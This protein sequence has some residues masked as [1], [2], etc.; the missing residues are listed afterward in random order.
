MNLQARRVS[1]PRQ[2]RRRK[3]DQKSWKVKFCILLYLLVT[4]SVFYGALNYSIDLNR[5]ISEL[6]R[7]SN[8]ARMEIQDIERDIKALNVEYQRLAS[9][10]N[11]HRQIARHNLP[12]R[13]SDPRQVRFF[14]VKYRN[15]KPDNTEYSA[16]NTAVTLS[17]AR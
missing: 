9:A 1:A 2:V 11:I 12:F 3:D 4:V 14:T 13:P 7:A 5:K 15:Y 16:H 6:R 8:R 17:S 10:A